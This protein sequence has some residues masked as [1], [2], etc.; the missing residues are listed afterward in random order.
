MTVLGGWVDG[1]SY[2][3]KM[4]QRPKLGLIR[5]KMWRGEKRIIDTGN[6][7]DNDP[8]LALRGGRVGVFSAGQGGVTWSALSYRYHVLCLILILIA[9]LLSS[10]DAPTLLSL[11]SSTNFPKICKSST[12]R[13]RLKQS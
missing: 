6:I 11:M 7:I 9:S 2:K 12:E 10:S 5:L 3:I 8:G 13:R 1:I 4:L